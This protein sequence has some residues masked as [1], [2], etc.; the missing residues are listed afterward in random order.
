MIFFLLIY[1]YIE[2]IL[3]EKIFDLKGEK[4]KV[5]VEIVYNKVVC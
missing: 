2:K 3:V 1:I 4:N 5:L